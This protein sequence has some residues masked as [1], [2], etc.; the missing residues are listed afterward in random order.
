MA[1][2]QTRRTFSVRRATYDAVRE[3]CAAR[4]VSMSDHI[5]A[6]IAAD[7]AARGLASVAVQRA[8]A[9]VQ[10]AGD[11]Q[12][13]RAAQKV[14]RQSAQ[15]HNVVSKAVATVGVPVP[16]KGQHFAVKAE[17]R[18]VAESVPLSVDGAHRDR[19]LQGVARV[20]VQRRVRDATTSPPPIRSGFEPRPVQAQAVKPERVPAPDPAR[21]A[22]NVVSF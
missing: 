11:R 16:G 17:V 20:A 15:T 10:R 21:G 6:L 4:D 3:D 14:L 18:R 9:A 7:R 12:V 22:R 8:V 1:K 2:V 19:L 5:E 13:E